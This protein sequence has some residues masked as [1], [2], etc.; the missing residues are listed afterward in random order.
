VGAGANCSVSVKFSP[1][2]AGAV[3]G[4]LTFTDSAGNSPQTVMLTGSG[5]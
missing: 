3:T 4:S 5:R 2:A 1:T